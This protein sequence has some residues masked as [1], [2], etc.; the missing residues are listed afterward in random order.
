MTSAA[1]RSLRSA[2]C[3]SRRAAPRAC[4]REAATRSSTCSTATATA[5]VG[6]PRV[7][8]GHGRGHLR[9]PRGSLVGRGRR[10]C[11][12]SSRSLVRDP[13]PAP[14]P[15]YA[16]VDLEAEGRKSA[17][18]ARQFV[19]GVCAESGCPSVTQFIG[20]VPP[21]PRARPLPPLRRGAL[22]PRG[23]GNAAHRRR[24][25]AARAGRVRPSAGDASSTASRTRA[26][27]RC[28]LLGVFRPSG[29]PAEAYYPDGTPAV[30]PERGD[31]PRIERTAEI[32]WEGNL[33]RGQ[34]LISAGSSGAF[35]GLAYSNASRIGSPKG[36]RAPRSCSRPR[37]AAA[38]RCRSPAS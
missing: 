5:T 1:A 8:L 13:E 22:H 32:A 30:Y 36:R 34:G 27:A 33:A 14:G 12:S 20:F 21:G 26:S 24:R 25:G 29:S 31:M 38:S 10:R 9:A 28:E 18:A 11:S 6:E 23:R 7:P 15:G 16:V 4:S 19:L 3:A 2:C 17:T 37:T 35:S